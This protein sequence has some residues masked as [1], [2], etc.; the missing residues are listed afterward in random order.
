MDVKGEVIVE[1]EKDVVWE[2][3]NDK[4]ILKAATPGCKSLTEV[5]PFHY[6]A[7][8][9]LGIAA[10]R[11]QY[12]ADIKIL[13]KQEPD[14]YRLVMNANSSMGFVE[15][16]AV[17]TLEFDEGKTIIMYDGTANVG[18]LIAGTG[19]RILSGIA[20]MIVKDFFKK[21]AKEIKKQT[22]N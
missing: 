5:E 16:D 10:V 17:V 2:A 12:E 6:K 7:E 21:I 13:D 3:L 22:S 11:G 1:A 20:K 8:V 14:Q 19:Q 18:G 15:G 9:S 4:E